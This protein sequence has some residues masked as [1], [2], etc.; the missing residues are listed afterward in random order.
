[1]GPGYVVFFFN[2]VSDTLVGPFTAS[3][4]SKKGV[5]PGAWSEVV[6][7]HT[8]SGNFRVEWETLHEVKHARRRFPFLKDLDACKLSSLQVEDLLSALNKAPLFRQT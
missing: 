7:A 1:L 8:F 2:T 4:S 3:G 6:D 5:E